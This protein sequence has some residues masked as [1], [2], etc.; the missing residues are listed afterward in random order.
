[1]PL[2]D[3][4]SATKASSP[5]L[6]E[7]LDAPVSNP[8]SAPPA[9]NHK[10]RMQPHEIYLLRE[11]FLLLDEWDAVGHEVIEPSPPLLKR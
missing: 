5:L 7:A 2:L 3:P 11:F 1:M 4:K 6:A 8:A 9:T 10:D